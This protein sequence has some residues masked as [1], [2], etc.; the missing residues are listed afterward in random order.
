MKSDFEKAFEQFIEENSMSEQDEKVIDKFEDGAVIVNQLTVGNLQKALAEFKP[1]TPMKVG[2]G[3]KAG[4]MGD[5]THCIVL[6]PEK[7]QLNEKDVGYQ[8]SL[9]IE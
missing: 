5:F 7:V 6:V 3:T 8:V 2:L 1:E 9:M 4:S